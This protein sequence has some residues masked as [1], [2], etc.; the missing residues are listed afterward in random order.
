MLVIGVPSGIQG[1]L[2][3]LSNVII[4][5]SI[6]GFG[7]LVMAGNAAGSNLEGFV[8]IAMNSVYKAALNFSGQN[9]GAKK[10][11]NIKII[12]LQTVLCAAVIGIF[13]GGIVLLFRDVFVGFYIT[14]DGTT[15]EAYRITLNAA[16]ERLFCIMPFYFMCGIMEALCGI[17]RGMGKST[18]TMIFSLVGA[19]A[20]RIIW[21][22][23]VFK[24][25]ITTPSGIFMSYPLSWLI[26]IILDVVYFIYLYRRLR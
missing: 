1:I 12:L 5:S 23:T 19:C 25:F 13:M 16:M 22:E 17:I 8:Y 4:Q 18:T 24:H 26:V 14:P 3:S 6:N 21:V 15:E 11:K 10:Y 20:F 2:F 9:M 7:D